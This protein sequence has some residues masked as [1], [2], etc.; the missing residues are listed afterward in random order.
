M[1]DPESLLRKFPPQL[2][3][4]M[5]QRALIAMAFASDPLQVI[6]DEFVSD[7]DI[8]FRAKLINLFLRPNEELN[9]SMLFIS[10]DLSVLLDLC[11][12]VIVM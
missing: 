12:R 4:G 11:S 7:L 1:P 6:A 2:S 5:R 3:G 8:S 10:H 9:M